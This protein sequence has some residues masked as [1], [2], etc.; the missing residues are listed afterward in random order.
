MVET[1]RQ[2]D[3]ERGERERRQSGERRQ[4]GESEEKYKH[5]TL[6]FGPDD[7]Y[8]YLLDCMGTSFSFLRNN[9]HYLSSHTT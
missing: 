4:R 8:L 6:T 5:T 3:S 9:M 2:R 7:I 1:E